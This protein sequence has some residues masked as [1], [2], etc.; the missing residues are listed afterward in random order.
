MRTVAQA[1]EEIIRRSP[2]L[3]E[4]ISESVANNAKIA[5]RIKPDVESY[6][7]EKVSETAIAMALHRLTPAARRTPFGMRFLK[8]VRDITVRSDLVEY[9]LPSGGDHGKLWDE[10]SRIGKNR[11]AF[12]NFSRGLQG[13]LLIV[14]GDVEAE[15]PRDLLRGRG[16]QRT[17][18]L[19][20]ITMRLPKESLNVP[21]MYYPILKA[22]AL[23]GISFVE[24]M[25]IDTEFSIL[26]KNADVDRAFS[27]IKRITA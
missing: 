1:V 11:D 26:F 20:A 7:M 21:G 27:V 9:V 10:L 2:F 8:K 6:L 23:E 4:A 3:E 15:I 13:S 24:V 22:L 12:I 14:G 19:S 5:R 18:D 16:I 25:S 17:G